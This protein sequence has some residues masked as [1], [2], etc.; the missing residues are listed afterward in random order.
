LSTDESAD[1][2]LAL[3]AL[4]NELPFIEKKLDWASPQTTDPKEH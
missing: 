2:V 1:V 3:I 4:R